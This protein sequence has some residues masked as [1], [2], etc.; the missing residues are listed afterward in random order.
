VKR[1]LIVKTSALGDIIHTFPALEYLHSI[2]RDTCVDWVVEAPFSEL[3]IS[4]PLVENVHCIDTKKWR[5][6]KGLGD[7]FRFSKKL[8]KIRYDVLFDFQGNSK[9][10]LINVIA[11]ANVKVGFGRKAISEWPNL[12]TTNVKANPGDRLNVREEN[13][14]LVQSYF[15]DNRPFFSSGVRLEICKEQEKNLEK[16]L[17]HPKFFNQKKIMICPGANWKNKQLKMSTLIAFL[18]KISETLCCRFLIVWGSSAEKTIAERINNRLSDCSEV[19]DKLTLPALQNLMAEM[20]LVIAMDSLPL[21]LAATTETRTFSVFG[22]SS[23]EKYRPTGEK[24]QSYQGSCPYNKM[25]TRRCP[26]IRSC[27]TGACM[28]EIHAKTLYEHAAPLLQD[29]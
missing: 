23:S 7:F 11:R 9:A 10:A 27:P 29:I 21:H 26:L 8:R 22:P 5:L 4:H 18:E 28:K 20:D 14:F 2:C 24:H 25:F 19:I 1:I 13:L 12:W 3:V 16:L 15:E 6:G 17:K